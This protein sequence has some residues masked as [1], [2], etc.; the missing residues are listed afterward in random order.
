MW[1]ELHQ[2]EFLVLLDMQSCTEYAAHIQGGTAQVIIQTHCTTCIV[3]CNEPE[4]VKYNIILGIVK[5]I[6]H[7]KI[8]R[9]TARKQ[10]LYCCQ[11]G[12]RNKM[13]WENNEIKKGEK[14]A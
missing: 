2:L 1:L 13:E 3:I 12:R 5:L 7:V 10:K 9:I 8:S 4:G 14:V 11:T 6:M